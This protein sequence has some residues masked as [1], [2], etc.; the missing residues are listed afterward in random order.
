MRSRDLTL[1]PIRDQTLC[2]ILLIQHDRLILIERHCNA[3]NVD[4]QQL[5]APT[6]IQIRCR[7]S[8]ARHYMYDTRSIRD[9]FGMFFNFSRALTP[10]ALVKYAAIV[11]ATCQWQS[12][13][14]DPILFMVSNTMSDLGPNCLCLNRE[15]VYMY[16][17]LLLLL[18]LSFPYF[19]SFLRSDYLYAIN[20]NIY[21]Y[22]NTPYG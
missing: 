10:S 15:I 17:D 2:T 7:P 14:C 19:T 16:C 8:F 20:V 11:L 9:I 5:T 6:L 3:K 18:L 22:Y 1:R 4:R 13:K 12:K 21:Q